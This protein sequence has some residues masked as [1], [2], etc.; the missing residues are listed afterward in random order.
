MAEQEAVIE[1]L[2][3][4]ISKLTKQLPAVKEIDEFTYALRQAN[5]KFQYMNILHYVTWIVTAVFLVLTIFVGYQAYQGRI[6]AKN[7]YEAIVDGVYNSKGWSVIEGS[8]SYQ[9][10]MERVKNG[11]EK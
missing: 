7:G 10:Y 9:I 8:R 1:D 4:E 11:L 2:N 5:S 3:A 6:W